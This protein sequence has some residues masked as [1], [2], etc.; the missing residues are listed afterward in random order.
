MDLFDVIRVRRPNLNRTSVAT[1]LNVVVPDTGVVGATSKVSVVLRKA[2]RVYPILPHRVT[3]E[4][5][6]VFEFKQLNFACSISG[7]Q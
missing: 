1:V 2:Q 3:S 6:S 4:S 7:K 5:V